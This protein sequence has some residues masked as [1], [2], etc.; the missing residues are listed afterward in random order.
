MEASWSPQRHLLELVDE[1]LAWSSRVTQTLEPDERALFDSAIEE[2]RKRQV[3]RLAAD[4]ERADPE[5]F[6]A[7]GFSYAQAISKTRSA[8]ISM[9]L[10]EAH[11]F[12]TR[13]GVT[14]DSELLAGA[15]GAV[16]E[17]LQ[18]AKNLSKWIEGI[19]ELVGVAG[20]AAQRANSLRKLLQRRRT[21]S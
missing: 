17:V 1:V 19:T 12:R 5:D 18:S 3:P 7:A 8:S 15:L 21:R 20:A 6:E 2:A 4:L 16:K 14:F 10:V 11:P 9:D 13:K